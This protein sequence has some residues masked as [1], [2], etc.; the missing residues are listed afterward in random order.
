[1][2]GDQGGKDASTDESGRV[3]QAQA[4][5]EP[6][7]GF[8]RELSQFFVVPSLI[9]LLCVGVFI[10]FGLIASDKKDAGAFLQ[11]VREGQGSERWMA[12]SVSLSIDDVASSSTSTGGSLR[13]TR[14]ME[15]HRR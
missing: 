2:S 6:E 1:M 12:A 11:Q 15:M 14:T 4:D 3:S 10:M 13:N 5:L 9:V 7:Q 8:I